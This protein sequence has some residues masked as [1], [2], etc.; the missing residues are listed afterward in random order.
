MESLRGFSTG[1]DLEM[2]SRYLLTSCATARLLK[3]IEQPVM[4]ERDLIRL[5]S[6][7]SFLVIVSF[8][9]CPHKD[10]DTMP[11]NTTINASPIGKIY[12]FS[13]LP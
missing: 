8:R 2:V 10:R 4:L 5:D 12:V 11:E 6:L 3:L 9:G 7:V 13:L 1:I